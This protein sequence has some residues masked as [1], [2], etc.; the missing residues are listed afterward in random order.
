MSR[1][2]RTLALIGALILVTADARG[3]GQ[4][5]STVPDQR[6]ATTT[7]LGDTGL[8]FVPT[9]EVLKNKDFSVSGYR[10]N[11]DVHEGFSDIS[12][13]LGTFAY[14]M[15][16]RAEI[17]GSVR[18]DTR[19]RRRY[20]NPL[21]LPSD[22]A[23]GGVV[24]DYPF[25]KQGWTG[26][27]FGDSI[28]GVKVA[29]ISQAHHSPVSIAIRPFVKLPTGDKDS[30]SGTG[31][32]DFEVD[33]IISGEVAKVAE[34]A[35]TFGYIKRGDPS[36]FDLSDGLRWGIGAQFPTRSPLKF[37]TEFWGEK[38]SKDTVVMSTPI[39][40]VDGSIPPALSTIQPQETLMFG[41]T[42]QTKKGIFVGAGLDWSAKAD[43][44]RGTKYGWQARIGYHPPS[45]AIPLPAPP[46]PAP[47]PPPPPPAPPAHTLTVRAQANPSTVET[48]QPSQ[49]TATAQDSIGC[50]I[51]YRWSAPT[52]TF[53]NAAQQN[54]VWTAPN[55]VG[56][57]PLTVTG[58]CASDQKS[59]SDTVNV[60][61]IQ[62]AV[63][64]FTFE[65]VYFDF[66]RY[67]LTDA[68]TRLLGE[69]VA[70]LRANP[71]LKMRI[72]GH[73]CSIGTAEYN[74][75]LGDR[76]ARSVMQYL[77]SNGIAAD[78]L[79]TVSFG[80]ENP[81]YDNSREETRRLNRRAAMTVQIVAGN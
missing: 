11:W 16:D 54:T 23:A 39:V 68:A 75:A 1:R 77:V 56:T 6:P 32:A 3:Q 36:G 46:P 51:T 71:D 74:L 25:I 10:T 62:R 59:A 40:G 52:G 5:G 65:D 60:Q 58:T 53:A 80:E 7:V 37:T 12:N 47:P 57:V 19:I 45:A 69:A 15:G 70:T 67:S 34:V 8:W 50:T 42:W 29:L 24:N 2:F 21:F 30:G 72:E 64:T 14:G 79:A 27:H 49:V 73:T 18:V 22:P 9:G 38:Y 48:G 78:R 33:G 41:A 26:D 76:R 81:K 20:R 63:R 4:T 35:G 13:F 66:D 43:K 28:V 31:K 55:Q 44:V 61:V 17:F